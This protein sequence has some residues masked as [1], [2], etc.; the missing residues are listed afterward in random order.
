MFTAIVVSSL[1]SSLA[2][3]IFRHKIEAFLSNI[4]S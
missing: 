4:L 2:T 1:V 3:Y